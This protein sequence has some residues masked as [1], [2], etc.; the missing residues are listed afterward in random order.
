MFSSYFHFLF[1]MRVSSVNLEFVLHW[2]KLY[3]G[4]VLIQAHPKASA[5]PY[6]A[7][8]ILIVCHARYD[9]PWV[10]EERPTP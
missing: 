2:K 7:A 8:L 4:L 3:F 1:I 6:T 10:R 5:K 9:A